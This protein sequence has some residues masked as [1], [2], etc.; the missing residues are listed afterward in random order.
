MFQAYIYNCQTFQCFLIYFDSTQ[1][2][3]LESFQLCEQLLKILQ[4]HYDEAID[5]ARTGL[6][7]SNGNEIQATLYKNIGW[8]KLERKQYAV[9][10]QYLQK[11][12]ELNSQ[13]ADAYCLLARLAEATARDPRVM[14]EACLL[15]NSSL[16][17][18]Q[19]WRQ[20]ILDRIWQ[21]KPLLR[22]YR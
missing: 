2:R 22:K 19:V 9:A 15:L 20:Q 16:P 17:E 8:S 7:D 11:S 14:W 4:K 13:R 10:E 5:I 3:L 18:V 12:L 1:Q 21:N 6:N